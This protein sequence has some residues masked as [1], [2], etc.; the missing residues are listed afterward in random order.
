MDAETY[1][2]LFKLLL[3]GDSC[4][5]KAGILM[6]FAFTSNI[7]KGM[8]CMKG[9]DEMSGLLLYTNNISYM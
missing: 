3:I 7:G 1:D 5:G 4:V 2:F 8:I 9:H 6:R